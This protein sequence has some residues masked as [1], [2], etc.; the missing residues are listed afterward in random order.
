MHPRMT[1]KLPYLLVVAALAI[2]AVVS[3]ALPAT[4]E[5]R[6]FRV[7]LSDGSIITVTVD[8]ACGSLPSLPGHG[9]SE[10]PGSCSTPALPTQPSAPAAPT[11]A[12]TPPSGG[13]NDG[14]GAN[15]SSSGSNGGSGSSGGK[16]S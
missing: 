14:S 2:V 8:A 15:N 3:F 10:I 9:V 1:K 6:T 13:S 4:A 7:R 16:S 11:T 12:V 5:Q